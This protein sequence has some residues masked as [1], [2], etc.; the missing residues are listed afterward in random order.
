VISGHLLCNLSVVLNIMWC[1]LMIGL[2]SLG[3]ILY[4]VNLKYLR[5][6]LN[7]NLLKINS[8]Q[9]SNKSNRMVE[10]SKPQFSFNP[11]FLAMELCTENLAHTLPNKMA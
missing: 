9:K 3:F 5:T 2:D 8:P 7:S 1:L 6:L 4:I 11:F 10:E